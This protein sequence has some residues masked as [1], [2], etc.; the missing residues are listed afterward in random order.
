[1]STH[2]ERWYCCTL[3]YGERGQRHFSAVV[4]A[5]SADQAL[6]EFQAQLGPDWTREGMVAVRE[7]A[8]VDGMTAWP[9]DP[10]LDGI[11]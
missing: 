8:T 7:G 6:A 11:A 3:A 10:G 5:W 2:R 4:R 9:E 1:V